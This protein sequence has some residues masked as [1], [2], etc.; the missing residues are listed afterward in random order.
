MGPRQVALT[1]EDFAFSEQFAGFFAKL[2]SKA[3]VW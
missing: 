1:Y 3:D 2:G